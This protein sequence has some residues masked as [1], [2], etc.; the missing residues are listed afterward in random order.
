LVGRPG[1]LR[2]VADIESD[3]CAIRG[4]PS[5]G[6]S[7]ILDSHRA[8][9]R[10]GRACSTL[11]AGRGGPPATASHLP[12]ATVVYAPAAVGLAPGLTVGWRRA[13]S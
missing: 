4:F 3:V 11:A 6:E 9:E 5:V 2:R 12:T 7:W 1:D 10:R 8:V 13:K